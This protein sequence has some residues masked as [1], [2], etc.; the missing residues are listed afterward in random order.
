MKVLSLFIHPHIV[1]NLY[2]LDTKEDFVNSEFS[3]L[4]VNYDFKKTIRNRSTL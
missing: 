3:F 1:P 2:E 4:L